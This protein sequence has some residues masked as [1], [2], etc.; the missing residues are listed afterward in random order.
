MAEAMRCLIKV[1]PL[2][3]PSLSTVDT[4]AR[5]AIESPDHFRPVVVEKESVEYK[6]RNTEF[7]RWS[8]PIKQNASMH[9][10]SA[11][12]TRRVKTAQEQVL[13]MFLTS[14]N[15]PTNNK[16]P[17]RD[18]KWNMKWN[19]KT[20]VRLE[21]L[22]G[23]AL[24]PLEKPSLE[25]ASFVPALPGL[26]SLF[27]DEAFK[28]SFST[29]PLL[30][31]EFI[32]QPG[33]KNYTSDLLPYKFPKVKAYFRY[34]D[35]QQG[36]SKL[37]LSFAAGNHEVLLPEEAVD[38]R[39]QTSQS[40]QMNNSRLARDTRDLREHVVANL[41]S[42]GRI[43]APDILLEI[44]KWTVGGME[45]NGKDDLIKTKFQFVGVTFTQSV[46][47]EHHGSPATYSTKQSGKLGAKYAQFSMV[48]GVNR[49]AK[50]IAIDDPPNAIR[51]FVA[52]AFMTAGLITKAAAASQTGMEKTEEKP[53]QRQTS[54]HRAQQ[55]GG[56]ISHSA[57]DA[58]K[59]D[60]P[61]TPF[62]TQIPKDT[63]NDPH[64]SNMLNNNAFPDDNNE[65]RP[66]TGQE[67]RTEEEQ[68]RWTESVA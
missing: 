21:A 50:P 43:T 51:E 32:A 25:V 29:R 12:I 64:L 39:F 38:I 41:Q 28:T 48:Y 20:E 47:G 27:A 59:L 11:S 9:A 62:D 49:L 46:W 40:I 33:P 65:A 13:K 23:H 68:G 58:V 17:K 24:F 7:G 22:Y 4:T 35:G 54:G 6:A 1:L 31:Y 52:N 36:L 55:A 10:A 8:L 66:S 61:R 18:P 26:S 42:G 5:N 60:K 16:N 2:K 63:I 14:P 44:P 15:Q 34:I 30:C 57:T 45:F 67:G 3:S 56:A 53:K 37:V 19:N